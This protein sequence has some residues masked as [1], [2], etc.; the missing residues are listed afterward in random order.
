MIAAQSMVISLGALLGYANGANDIS[1]AVGMPMG[2][3]ARWLFPL[4]A[5]AMAAGAL[6]SG[7]RVTAVL[8]EE[9]TPM[10]HHDGLSSNLVTSILIGAG[11]MLGLPMSTTHVSSGGIAA[12]AATRGSRNSAATRSIALAWVVT[13]PAAGLLALLGRLVLGA[14]V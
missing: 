7:R 2:L 1:A 10:N 11:A 6:V 9:V 5:L 8:A 13:L 3:D 4:V 14:F 12:I